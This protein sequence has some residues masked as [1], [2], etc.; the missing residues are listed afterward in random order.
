MAKLAIE[1]SGRSRSFNLAACKR[2]KIVRDIVNEAV[3][4][5]GR[6]RSFDGVTGI[7][8]IKTGSKF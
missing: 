7:E 8:V 5:G 3:A 2:R 6:C 4:G 1:C